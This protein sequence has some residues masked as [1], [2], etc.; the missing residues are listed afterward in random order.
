MISATVRIAIR[1]C[2]QVVP[3]ASKNCPGPTPTSAAVMIAESRIA[4]PVASGWNT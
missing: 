4:V 2:L 3:T 1:L